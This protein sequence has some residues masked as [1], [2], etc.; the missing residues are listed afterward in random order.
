MNQIDTNIKHMNF[1]DIGRMD[2]NLL[3]VFEALYEEGGASR[4][5]I[6]LDLTQ[7]AVS[8]G[9]S[10]LR[11]L[12]QDPLFVRTGRGLLPTPRADEL[13]PILDEALDK[14]R[15]SLALLQHSG[16]QFGRTLSIGMSD[17][18]EISIGKALLALVAEK[19][20]GIRLIFRQTHSGIVG[21][22]LLSRSIDLAIASG[23]FSGNGL[24]RSVVGTGAYACLLDANVDTPFSTFPTAL[25]LDDFL[26][27][28]HLLVSSGGVVGIVDEVLSTI[29]RKREVHASTTHFAALPYLLL[30]SA[31]VATIPAHAAHAI[32]RISGLRVYSCP[33][34][35]PSYPIEVGWRTGAQRDPALMLIKNLIGDC[36]Q[37][38]IPPN[39]SGQAAVLPA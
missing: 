8:A 16:E 15:Q 34:A 23:G 30:Q 14:C 11:V 2:L 35:L 28:K 25:S 6:R 24:S 9:L 32:A 20:L 1:I 7:S 19:N 29:G 10:R 13:K 36:M 4:A 3:K 21:D 37:R 22:A 39:T 26:R 18:F 5:A 17:D 12:Y 33:I 31:A 27:R 38:L